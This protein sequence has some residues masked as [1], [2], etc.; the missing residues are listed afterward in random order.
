LVVMGM[1][2]FSVF[3]FIIPVIGL[4][5]GPILFLLG[6]CI[7]LGALFNDTHKG[8]CPMCGNRL[9]INDA[10]KCGM[11]KKRVIRKGK[12]FHVVL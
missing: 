7:S 5:G 1:T 3:V 2:V 4:F 8:H 6:L 10:L 11:C 9:L 12:Y